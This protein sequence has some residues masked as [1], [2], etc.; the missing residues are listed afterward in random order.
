MLRIAAATLIIIVS[1]SLSSAGER[2]APYPVPSG[3]D[4]GA[5][6]DDGGSRSLTVLLQLNTKAERYCW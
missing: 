4:G 1:A 6:S 2:I 3:W 5:Y